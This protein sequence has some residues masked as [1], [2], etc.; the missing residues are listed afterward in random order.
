[1]Q[2]Q[3]IGRLYEQDDKCRCKKPH[4]HLPASLLRDQEKTEYKYP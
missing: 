4:R 1:M 3:V 2:I